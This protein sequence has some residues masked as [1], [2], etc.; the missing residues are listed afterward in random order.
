[1]DIEIADIHLTEELYK[2]FISADFPSNELRQLKMIKSLMKNGFYSVYAAYENGE[3]TG[4]ACFLKGKTIKNT[5]L[6]DYF[7]VRK[8]L[9]G[10]G[11]GSLFLSQLVGHIRK[12]EPYVSFIAVECE[13]PEKTSV[14]EK[15]ENRRRRIRFYTQ[16]GAVI[17]D[18]GWYVFGVDYNLLVIKTS[19]KTVPDNFAENLYRLYMEG[20]S[21]NPFF[22]EIAKKRIKIYPLN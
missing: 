10:Q 4:Y 8:D 22:R 13:N 11:K 7:A 20:L 9:R 15:A 5:V 3:I 17:T 18:T 19:D 2:K 12:T 21:L 14:S 6:L 16:N 1:M